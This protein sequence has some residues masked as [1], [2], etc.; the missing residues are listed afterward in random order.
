MANSIEKENYSWFIQHYPYHIRVD[1]KKGFFFYKSIIDNMS[2]TRPFWSRFIW[3]E[4]TVAHSEEEY[5]GFKNE[6]DLLMFK[7]AI[8]DQK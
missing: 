4:N 1:H 8:G 2:I 7:L 6:K 5:W 3:L